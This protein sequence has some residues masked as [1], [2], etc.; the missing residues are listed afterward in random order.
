MQALGKIRTLIRML[1]AAT[2]GLLLAW[3]LFYGWV[4]LV[5]PALNS[6]DSSVSSTTPAADPNDDTPAH[7]QLSQPDGAVILASGSS[8]GHGESSHAE[9][10]H[11]QPAHD[12]AAEPVA[13]TE[14]VHGPPIASEATLAAGDETVSRLVE[15]ADRAYENGSLADCVRRYQ[16]LLPNTQGIQR[17]MVA[18]KLGIAAEN[19]SDLDTAANAYA[20][21]LEENPNDEL[22]ALARIRLGVIIA[23]GGDFAGAR[24]HLCDWLLSGGLSN[25]SRYE[26]QGLHLMGEVQARIACGS[27]AHDATIGLSCLRDDRPVWPFKHDAPLV[28]LKE[29]DATLTA[30][31]PPS[32]EQATLIEIVD[33]LSPAPEETFASV[34]VA[35]RPLAG[36]C[37]ALA[38]K[39][40]LS[41]A[42]SEAAYGRASERN[43]TL[44]LSGVN[45]AVI[46]DLLTRGTGL[47]WLQNND[48]IVIAADSDLSTSDL[49]LIDSAVARRLLQFAIATHPENE[50]MRLTALS[51]A[52][53]DFHEGRLGD[54]SSRYEQLVNLESDRMWTTE[55]AFNLGKVRLLLNDM[56]GANAAFLRSSDVALGHPLQ[57]VALMYAGRTHVALNKVSDS[58]PLFS[59]AWTL[60]RGSELEPEALISLCSIYAYLGNPMAANQILVDHRDVVRDAGHYHDLA[61]F[62]G[63]YCRHSLAQSNARKLRDGRDLLDAL[64]NVDPTAF[65][66]MQGWALVIQAYHRLGL[67]QESHAALQQCLT[68]SEDSVFL[69]ELVR[70][71]A[72]GTM[73]HE[74]VTR[75]QESDD[76]EQYSALLGDETLHR[77][78]RVNTLLD[79]GSH[80]ELQ[81]EAELLLSEP[82]TA[83]MQVRLLD[84]LGRSYQRQGEHYDAALCFAR[85]NPFS[86]S[87]IRLRHEYLQGHTIPTG[88]TAP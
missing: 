41:I 15:V 37:D 60:S 2:L 27:T 73:Q 82:L 28:E 36:V 20:V 63:C 52:N 23:A 50:R 69:N 65:F 11:D 40:G 8:A 9:S 33:R 38:R 62:V 13:P 1:A 3:T 81:A 49:A 32:T 84:M 88:A 86:E 75:S 80:A 55:A 24:S 79:A 87:A 12:E 14:P 51:L 44:T 61:A 78:E 30:E 26:Q 59:R 56:K 48:G 71:E 22:A 21:S 16:F 17:R 70:S 54:A 83:S 85:I 74:G 31:T 45:L 10:S 19:L 5:S 76:F 18:V 67:D 7:R 42:W 29:L 35:A 25:R 47:V 46:F 6:Q 34:Q 43:V 64:A 58:L 53:L 68:A 39:A 4:G 66:S 72:A 77:M 57:P